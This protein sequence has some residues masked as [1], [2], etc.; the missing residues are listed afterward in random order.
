LTIDASAVGAPVNRAE[1]ERRIRTALTA[2]SLFVDALSLGNSELL[3]YYRNFHY[4]AETD[5]IDR[6]VRVLSKEA[7]P[8]IE[9]F[10]LIAVQA[11]V[12]QQ[13]FDIL[14]SPLERS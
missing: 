11:G 7:P 13:E 14:R 3:L 9:R 8:Q 12:P 4:R 2:Q 5:A 1:T 6:I 10:R